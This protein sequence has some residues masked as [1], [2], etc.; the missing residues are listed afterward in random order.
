[1]NV[2]LFQTTQINGSTTR[3]AVVDND[4]VAPAP[5]QHKKQIAKPAGKFVT[6]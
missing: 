2:L 1:M 5:P 6:Y 4:F 3:V